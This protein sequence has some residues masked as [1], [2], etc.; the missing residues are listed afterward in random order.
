MSPAEPSAYLCTMNPLGRRTWKE[1]LQLLLDLLVGTVGFS[2]VM[3][4]LATEV[5]C[6]D[7]T[8]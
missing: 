3:V 5:V 6:A 2:L 8:A 1:T 7:R 4:G